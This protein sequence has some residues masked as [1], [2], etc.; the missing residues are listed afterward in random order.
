M[1]V[2]GMKTDERLASLLVL[3]PLSTT[4]SYRRFILLSSLLRV[5]RVLQANFFVVGTSRVAPSVAREVARS[6]GRESRE[7][8]A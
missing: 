4:P 3:N 5:L 1:M 7:R 8:V 6:R 2:M